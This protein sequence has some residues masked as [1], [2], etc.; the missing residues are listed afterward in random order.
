MVI[1]Y[2]DCLPDWNVHVCLYVFSYF[3]N[4]WSM[5]VYM[6]SRICAFLEGCVKVHPDSFQ[7]NVFYHLTHTHSLTLTRIH[8]HP[9]PT[10]KQADWQAD[11]HTHTHTYTHTHI[12]THKRNRFYPASYWLIVSYLFQSKIITFCR[13]KLIALNDTKCNY[14]QD[15]SLYNK[16]MV[17]EPLV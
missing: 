8:T 15:Q 5:C 4:S 6:F 9:H 17:N 12:H 14:G 2:F 3:C 13:H 10:H 7:I 11:T 1:W 16:M